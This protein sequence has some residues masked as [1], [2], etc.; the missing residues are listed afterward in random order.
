MNASGRIIFDSGESATSGAWIYVALDFS[1]RI[2]YVGQT[3][4]RNGVAGRWLQ[5][6]TTPD[7]GF[8]RRCSEYDENAQ[9]NVRPIVVFWSLASDKRFQ[10]E[11]STMREAVEY[12][13]QIG[14][15]V[16][17]AKLSPP[18]TIISWVRSNATVHFPVVIEEA[19]RILQDFELFYPK[20]YRGPV[21]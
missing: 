17:M 9:R 11:E 4:S 20:M 21:G 2:A 10:S 18:F 16:L 5:H 12:L 7:S 19:E 1:Y 3:N 14:L 8:Q 6:L 15:R 13:V